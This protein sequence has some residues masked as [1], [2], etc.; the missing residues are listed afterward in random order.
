MIE[1][2]KERLVPRNIYA[3]LPLVKKGEIMQMSLVTGSN[4]LNRVGKD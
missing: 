4:L 3:K 2:K 1:R